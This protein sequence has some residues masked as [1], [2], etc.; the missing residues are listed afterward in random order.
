MTK[1]KKGT[2]ILVSIILGVILLALFK[3]SNI[4]ILIITGFI[5]T[6][7]T[8]SEER[9]YK[10]GGIASGFLGILIFLFGFFS[11]PNIPYNL[12]TI[13]DLSMIPLIFGGVITLF[14]GFIIS[15]LISAAMGIIGGFIAKKVLHKEEIHNNF[16]LRKN[17]LRKNNLQLRKY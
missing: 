11:F 15:S 4:P 13:L 16:N 17:S 5:A 3:F 8:I 1:Y 10:V 7:L 14:L 2:A 6:Y 12:P 9:N